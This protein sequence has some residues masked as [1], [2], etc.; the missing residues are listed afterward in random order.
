MVMVLQ[1]NRIRGY[2][3]IYYKELTG[4]WFKMVMLGDLEFT[5][6][7]RHTEIYRYI[8][9]FPLR[10]EPLRLAEQ[11]LYIREKPDQS[12][13]EKLRYNLAINP[14]PSQQSAIRRKTQTQDFSLGRERFRPHI[15]HPNFE[16]WYLRQELS[17]YL[18][19]KINKADAHETRAVVN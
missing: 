14:L 10:K 12:G 8:K 1:R 16:N 5:A 17:K 11:P 9:Q 15:R 4:F 2:G 19:L 18:A 7:C 3:E 13:K 6:S